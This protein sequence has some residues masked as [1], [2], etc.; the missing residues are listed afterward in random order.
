MCT[1]ID[2]VANDWGRS[3]AEV[4]ARRLPLLG[5]VASATV[6]LV[7]MVAVRLGSESAADA[8]LSVTPALGR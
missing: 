5:D 7:A 1:G 8:S 2:P 6:V 4:R 3:L